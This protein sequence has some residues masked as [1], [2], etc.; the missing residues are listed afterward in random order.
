MVYLRHWRQSGDPDSRDKAYELLRGLTYLQT[1]TGPN[2][3]NVV[4]WMQTDGTLNR[5]PEPVELPDPSDSGPL[6]DGADDLGPG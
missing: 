5:S 6:L 4:L 3:G 1:T 2:R